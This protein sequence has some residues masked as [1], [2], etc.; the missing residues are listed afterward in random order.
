[1]RYLESKNLV[2]RDLATRNIL[3]DNAYVC[4]IADF[5]LATILEK[6]QKNATTG[7]L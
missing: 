5:G 6:S 2:H 1:M 7:K 3:V 4:K